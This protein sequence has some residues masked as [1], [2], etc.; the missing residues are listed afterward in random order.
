MNRNLFMWKVL[1]NIRRSGLNITGF[2]LFFESFHS[3]YQIVNVII[4]LFHIS[5]DFFYFFFMLN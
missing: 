3:N 5:D 1:A 4:L 2:V